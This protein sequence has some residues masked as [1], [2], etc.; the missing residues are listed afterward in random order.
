MEFPLNLNQF[1]FNIS[2]EY[3]NSLQNKQYNLEFRLVP[4]LGYEFKNQNGLEIGI[5]FRSDFLPDD[6]SRNIFWVNSSYY[7]SF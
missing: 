7:L 2:Y 3:L 4:I 5:K 1:Y 6:S